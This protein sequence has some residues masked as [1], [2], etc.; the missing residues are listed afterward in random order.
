M[1]RPNDRRRPGL[2]P[3]LLIALLSVSLVAAP[4][5]AKKKKKPPPPP[6]P[7]PVVEA[8]PEKIDVAALMQELHPDARV[9]FP[10]DAAPVSRELATGAI[11][12]ADALAKG[13]PAALEKMLAPRDRGILQDL[14]ETG[15]FDEAAKKIEAVRIVYVSESESGGDAGGE[16]AGGMEMSPEK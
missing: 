1:T 11:R 16:N 5:C 8:P 12:L 10:Q 13:D 9:Q 4:G 6:P 2:V 3:T 14:R 7:P 15:Q